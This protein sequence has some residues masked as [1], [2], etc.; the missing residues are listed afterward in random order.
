MQLQYWSRLEGSIIFWVG[1]ATGIVKQVCFERFVDWVRFLL[2]PRIS[3]GSV[4]DIKMV[5]NNDSSHASKFRSNEN[6]ILATVP[7]IKFSGTHL[8]T[9]V[10]GERHCES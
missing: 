10:S 6:Y 3:G 7:S 9:S 4:Q 2:L 5:I 8:Y 1:I